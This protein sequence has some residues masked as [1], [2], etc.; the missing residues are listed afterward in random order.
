MSQQG[1]RTA[2]EIRR[3]LRFS[4]RD[5]MLFSVMVGCGEAYFVAFALAVG[6]GET[7]AGLLGSVPLLAGALLQLAGPS[8]VRAL[9]SHKRWVVLAAGLQ[10]L[11]FIPMIIAAVV[12][13]MPDWLIFVMVSLYWAFNLG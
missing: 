3:D 6:M 5:A 2:A 4:T 7:L 1:T 9:G 8:A 13:H 10:A 11:S 12:G